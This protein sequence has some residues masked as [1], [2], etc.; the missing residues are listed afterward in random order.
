MQSIARDGKGSVSS[1]VS[2]ITEYKFSRYGFCAKY[3][4]TSPTVWICT[5][6]AEFN[7]NNPKIEVLR[8]HESQNTALR[9]TNLKIRGLN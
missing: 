5:K 8:N 6:S 2:P 7:T 9:Q 1:T 4:K 3:V